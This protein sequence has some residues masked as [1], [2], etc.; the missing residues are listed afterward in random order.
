MIAELVAATAVLGAIGFAVSERRQR[1]RWAA[2]LEALDLALREREFIADQG[3][4]VPPEIAS[5]L[6]SIRALQAGKT[7]LAGQAQLRLM[8]ETMFN[9]LRHGVIV[10]SADFAIQFANRAVSTLFPGVDPKSHRKLIEEIRDHELDAL[11]HEALSRNAPRTR[12]IRRQTDSMEERVYFAEAAPLPGPQGSGVWIMIEDVTD[13]LMT[14]QIRKDFVANASHELRTPLTM[15][16]GYIETLQDGALD[17]PGFAR[18]CLDVMEKH[19]KRIARIVEDMLAISRLESSAA[20]L[21]IEPFKVQSCVKDVLEHLTPIIEARKPRISLHFPQDG[22][23]LHGDRF[24]WDQIFTNL[25]ENAIKENTRTGLQLTV[26]GEWRADQIILTVADNGV[27]IAAHD[28][29]FVFKR[30]YR[31]AKSHSQE[32]KGTGLG[33]SIV[34]RAVEAHGGTI[35]LRSTPG[36]ETVFT[37][38]LPVTGSAVE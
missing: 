18:R 15:I 26:T 4:T 1:E 8:Y 30:F 35:D 10:T 5:L 24:Y 20:L 12:H 32:I 36:V 25:I 27:G 11:A 22:G 2:G 28:L 3:V 29:P 38:H 14:E 33:L 17:D 13:R 9:E 7:A 34:K 37:M 6:P 31:G 23:I 16:N 21:K 19:G